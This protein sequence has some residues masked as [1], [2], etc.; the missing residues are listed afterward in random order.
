MRF[1]APVVRREPSLY[2]RA[3]DTKIVEARCPG[4]GAA[5]QFESGQKKAFCNY[6]GSPVTV[7]D[8][9]EHVTRNIDEADLKRAETEQLIRLKE[10][11]LRE[12]EMEREARTKPLK[13]GGCILLGVI[14]A[15]CIVIGWSGEHSSIGLLYV[16]LICLIAVMC[17]APSGSDK[18]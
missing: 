1:Q 5:V 9:E 18:K 12:R 10:L 14:G 4:C 3:M 6:C 17:I 15:V 11:E 7:E 13:T 2:G 16:G 8:A